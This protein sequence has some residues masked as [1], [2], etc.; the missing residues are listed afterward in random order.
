MATNLQIIFVSNDGMFFKVDTTD[1]TVSPFSNIIKNVHKMH[2]ND[3]CVH[4][5]VKISHLVLG[6]ILERSSVHYEVLKMS[7][8]DSLKVI[9]NMTEVDTTVN[10]IETDLTS[11]PIDDFLADLSKD[12]VILYSH[13][14]VD[15]S[16]EF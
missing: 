12:D 2:I 4:L 11:N 3:V 13:M 9:F 8:F 5:M 10:V 1:L 16:M 7:F 14:D 15:V 6:H